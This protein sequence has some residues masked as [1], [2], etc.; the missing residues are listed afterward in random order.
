MDELADYLDRTDAADLP[1]EPADDVQVER[2]E[3]EQ[4]LVRLPKTDL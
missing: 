2:P 3:P 1:W 4:I